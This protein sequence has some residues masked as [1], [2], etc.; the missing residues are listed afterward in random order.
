MR[1]RN[2]SCPLSCP[3]SGFGGKKRDAL[4]QV[5]HQC[6]F[7]VFARNFCWKRRE[8]EASPPHQMSNN[9]MTKQRKMEN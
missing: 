3:L 9:Q 7:L 6:L 2:I 4:V 5:Q 1:Q 8:Q